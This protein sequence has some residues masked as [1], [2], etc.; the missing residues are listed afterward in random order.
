Q[1]GW[2]LVPVRIVH[3]ALLS[4]FTTATLVYVADVARPERRGAAISEMGVAN[5]VGIAL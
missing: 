3:G 4:V 5:Y 2:L 1:G